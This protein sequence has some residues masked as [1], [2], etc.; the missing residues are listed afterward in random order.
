MSYESDLYAWTKE[1]A[2]ALRRR[3]SNALDWENLAEEIE[4]VGTS[5]RSE[6][7][8]RLKVLL[9]HLLKWKCQP[10]LQCGSW[11]ASIREARDEIGD[12]LE[13]SPSLRAY[14]LECLPKA[15][16]RARMKALDE[17][18]LLRLAETCPWTIEEI[19]DGDFLP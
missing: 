3:A 2:D 14:P 7:R 12:L 5:Q 13:D 10:E 15:Y 8:S 4:S 19:L 11:R 18:G 6:I 17:T 9:V 1:Q 16:A